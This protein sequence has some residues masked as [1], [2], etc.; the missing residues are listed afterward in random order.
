MRW[1]PILFVSAATRQRCG[2]L[3]DVMDGAPTSHLHVGVERGAE[4]CGA[5][6]AAAREEERCAGEDLLWQSGIDASTHYRGVRERS[7]ARERQLLQ[8]PR[9]EDEG[10]P[11]RVQEHADPVDVLWKEGEGCHQEYERGAGRW[12]IWHELSVPPCRLSVSYQRCGGVH[13]YSAG[14]S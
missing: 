14:V 11:G 1:A 4:G 9:Q 8:V 6:A 7:E 12:R 13:T 5:V 3:Y 10:E 2:K